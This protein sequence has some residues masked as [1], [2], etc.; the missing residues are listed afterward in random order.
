MTGL[1][2]NSCVEQPNFATNYF[3]MEDALALENANVTQDGYTTYGAFYNQSI[4]VTT[5]TFV[6]PLCSEGNEPFF[7][8]DTIYS[9][10]WNYDSPATAGMIGLAFGSSFWNILSDSL[11]Q[12]YWYQI[13]FSNVTDWTF[14]NPNYQPQSTGNSIEFGSG[15]AGSFSNQINQAISSNI[16]IKPT[17]SVSQLF[18]L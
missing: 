17:T 14:A 6:G 16:T 9:N 11:D 2:G 12:G 10:N 13:Q 15:T 4:C 7:V 3:K 1:G 5:T 18:S 8:A